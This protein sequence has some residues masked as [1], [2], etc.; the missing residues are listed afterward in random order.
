LRIKKELAK[1]KFSPGPPPTAARI[2]AAFSVKDAVNTKAAR[3]PAMLL[4]DYLDN[5]AGDFLSYGQSKSI[6]RRSVHNKS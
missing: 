4:A 6:P 5:P 2:E 1:K 3:S